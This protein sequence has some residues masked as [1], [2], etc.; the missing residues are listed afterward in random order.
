MHILIHTVVAC[1]PAEEPGIRRRI[2][3]ALR[4]RYLAGPDG[5]SGWTL[6]TDGPADLRPADADLAARLP[7]G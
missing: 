5:P 7:A 6:V 1:E 4:S 2:A 3:A